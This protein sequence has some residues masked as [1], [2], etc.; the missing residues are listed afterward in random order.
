M[1]DESFT[2]IRSVLCVK[3]LTDRRTDRQRNRQRDRQTDKDKEKD[4]Q[5]TGKSY[6]LLGRRNKTDK[7]MKHL[8]PQNIRH[9]YEQKHII[10]GKR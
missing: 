5:T 2:E 4:R 3:L 8:L 9:R 7:G 1:S 6:S 10:I